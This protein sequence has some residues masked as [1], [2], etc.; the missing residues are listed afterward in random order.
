MEQVNFLFCDN[1]LNHMQVD[2][3][4]I[5]EYEEAHK[6][7]KCA[8]FSYENLQAGPQQLAPESFYQAITVSENQQPEA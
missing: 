1:P 8:L 3:D 6:N 7:H 4:Y 2:E 5:E